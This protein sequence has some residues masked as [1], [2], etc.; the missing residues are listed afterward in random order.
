MAFSRKNLDISSYLVVGPE[1]TLS[2]PVPDIVSAAVKGGFSCVQLRSKT[3]SAREMIDLCLACS[4]AIRSLGAGERVALLVDDRLDVA[5]A[6][7]AAGADVAGV[8]V[9]QSD[10]PPAVCRAYLGE[11]AVVGLSAPTEELFDYVA[12]AD[13][14]P[15][16]YF[17]AGPL[18]AT[19]TKPDCGLRADGTIL[20]RTFAD[21]AR[22]AEASPIPVVFGG[23]VK[24]PD[25]PQLAAT[26]IGGF[27]VVS[28]VAGAPDP[29]AAAAALVRAWRG[30]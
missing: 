27:F 16:D 8:H 24:L 25:L 26:G 1:N 15:L 6:A 9:G 5:L 18:R 14:A 10:I 17:G 20:E 30:A 11:D 28:A 29:E 12:T 23:G 22:L 7:R 19:P 2:R 21:I 3:A 4:R 13:L